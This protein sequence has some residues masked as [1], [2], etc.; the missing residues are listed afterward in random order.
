MHEVQNLLNQG[1]HL[2]LLT[3]HVALLLEGH[4]HPYRLLIPLRLSLNQTDVLGYLSL[5]LLFVLRL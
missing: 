2:V 3:V 5:L 4:I 1:H